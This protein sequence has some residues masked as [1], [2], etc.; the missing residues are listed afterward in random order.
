MWALVL[1]GGRSRR[2]GRPKQELELG[3]LTLLER[4]VAAAREVAEEVVVVGDPAAAAR[5]GAHAAADLVAGQG[6]LSG[7]A[8]GLAVCPEGLHALLACDLPFVEPALLSRLE[9]LAGGAD[10]VVPAVDGRRHPLC[11]L[12]HSDCLETARSC[13]AAGRRRMEDLLER[14]NVRSVGPEEALPAPLTR[15]VLNVNTPED[16]QRALEAL[17][18]SNDDR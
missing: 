2:M 8:G 1:A 6:P 14:V 11:A 4:V 5:V 18:V 7:L 13:L 16:Y 17:E 10:A 12:Y 15:A 3:G 9:D